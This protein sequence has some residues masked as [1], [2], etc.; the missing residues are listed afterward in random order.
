MLVDISLANFN[1]QTRRTRMSGDFVSNESSAGSS[2][3]CCFLLPESRCRCCASENNEWEAMAGGREER[4]LCTPF[5]DSGTLAHCQTPPSSPCPMK[6]YG[7]IDHGEQHHRRLEPSPPQHRAIILITS[8]RNTGTYQSRESDVAVVWKEFGGEEGVFLLASFVRIGSL[9]AT[10]SCTGIPPLPMHGHMECGRATS[11]LQS[12]DLTVS[13]FPP[14]RIAM[15]G[16]TDITRARP[17]F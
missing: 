2:P 10:M 5:P 14:P 3:V 1:L 9:Q 17:P 4:V 11:S 13:S 15:W 8:N 7:G 6:P 12:G 16:R